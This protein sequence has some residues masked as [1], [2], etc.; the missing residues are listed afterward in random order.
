MASI[1]MSFQCI[2]LKLIKLSMWLPS[3][4]LG[5]WWQK[6]TF[7][8]RTLTLHCTC[9]PFSIRDEMAW[10]VL[11]GHSL[12]ANM[13]VW[14]LVNQPNVADL[15]TILTTSP[16]PASSDQCARNLHTSRMVCLSLGLPPH[17]ASVL[18]LSLDWLSVELRW[19][20][21]S[22]LR[23]SQQKNWRY[24]WSWSTLSWLVSGVP[25]NNRRNDWPSPPVS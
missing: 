17:P 7:Y 15:L 21:F 10:E 9:G 22:R 24:C 6:F 25:G 14:I 1:P 18:A 13:V 16:L 20:L 4:G 23:I 8:Q 5:V 12:V 11:C 2:T 19:T 3:L